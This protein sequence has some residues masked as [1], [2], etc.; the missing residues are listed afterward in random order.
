MSAL[1]P[2]PPPS[3]TLPIYGAHLSLILLQALQQTHTLMSFAKILRIKIG[4]NEVVPP[5]LP[6][7]HM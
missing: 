3:Y 7:P 1:S 2:L 4:K 5:G 6:L